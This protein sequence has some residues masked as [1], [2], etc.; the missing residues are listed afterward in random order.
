[1]S[2]H[3]VRHPIQNEIKCVAALFLR[4]EKEEQRWHGGVLPLENPG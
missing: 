4:T 1:M 2:A 3:R